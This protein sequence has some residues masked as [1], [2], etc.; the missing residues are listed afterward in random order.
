MKINKPSSQQQSNNSTFKVSTSSLLR[1]L[2]KIFDEAT[3]APTHLSKNTYS[4]EHVCRDL[5]D[6]FKPFISH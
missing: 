5:K 2:K 3:E 4:L 1:S 6:L